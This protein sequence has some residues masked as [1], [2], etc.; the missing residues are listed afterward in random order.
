M[1]QFL[2]QKLAAQCDYSICPLLLFV[3]V[4]INNSKHW[5]VEF[6]AAS[7]SERQTQP[8]LCKQMEL[9]FATLDNHFSQWKTQKIKVVTT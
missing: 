5:Q 6:S 1:I 4:Q 2:K 8:C 9:T 3:C 7:Y